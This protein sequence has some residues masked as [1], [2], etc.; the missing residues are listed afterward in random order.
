MDAVPLIA[1]API[2]SDGAIV[3][4]GTIL[5]V[6]HI[7][8]KVLD[9]K[10]KVKVAANGHGKSQ[11]V[12]QCPGQPVGTKTRDGIAKVEQVAEDVVQL[13]LDMA[14]TKTDVG[15]I[16]KDIKAMTNQMLVLMGKQPEPASDDAPAT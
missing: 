15:Y 13:K 10:T 9:G 12:Y 16:R 4:L 14:V 11:P 1:V 3:G 7:A 5:G 2:V 8:G 6:V